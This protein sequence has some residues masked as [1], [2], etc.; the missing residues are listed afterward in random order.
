MDGELKASG[1]G[2]GPLD[3]DWGYKATIGSFDFY[4]R[5][6]KGMLDEFY[7]FDYAISHQRVK[8]LINFKCTYKVANATTLE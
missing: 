6:L 7:M 5:F 2:L 3:R 1:E 4:G 8:S